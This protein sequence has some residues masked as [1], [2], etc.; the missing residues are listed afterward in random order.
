MTERDQAN[1]DDLKD[2]EAALIEARQ[3]LTRAMAGGGRAEREKFV[4][5]V[6]FARGRLSRL[7]ARIYE[8]G[9]FGEATQ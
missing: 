1:L 6:G 2:A 4:F 9:E 8:A 7:S 3:A 5:Q